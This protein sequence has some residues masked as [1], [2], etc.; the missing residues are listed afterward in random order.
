MQAPAEHAS[1]APQDVPSLFLSVTVQVPG[2][3]REVHVSAPMWHGFAGSHAVP[4]T[5][6]GAT[7]DPPLHTF[8]LPQEVP[9]DLLLVT[10]QLGSEVAVGHELVPMVQAFAGWHT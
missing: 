6:F 2:A 3:D 4:C 9:S 8:P 1:P 7:H 10:L 5:Q